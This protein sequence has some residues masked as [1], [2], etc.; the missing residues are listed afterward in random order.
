MAYFIAPLRMH[1]K[2]FKST[3]DSLESIFNGLGGNGC[4]VSLKSQMWPSLN[5][6]QVPA[7]TAPPGGG[8]GVF[9]I[10]PSKT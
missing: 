4:W 2:R 8:G 3:L 10:T 6:V 5:M 1:F 7:W 9:R